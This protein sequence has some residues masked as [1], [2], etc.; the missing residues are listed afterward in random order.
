MQLKGLL[1]AGL[2]KKPTQK[3]APQVWS[4]CRLNM[5]CP[6]PAGWLDCK[7]NRYGT[8]LPSMRSSNQIAQFTSPLGYGLSEFR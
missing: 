3:R 4:F 1:A 7:S 5:S 2:L 6:T 8:S